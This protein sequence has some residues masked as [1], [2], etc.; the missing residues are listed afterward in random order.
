TELNG[1]S[2][3]ELLTYK[4]DDG[5][6]HWVGFHNFFVITRYNRSVMYALAAYQLGREI[7]GRVDAE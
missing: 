5:T 2:K 3:G 4:G 1:D 7:A 6:E